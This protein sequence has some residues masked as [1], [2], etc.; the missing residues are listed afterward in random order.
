MTN[1]IP[2]PKIREA[3][4]YL[5]ETAGEHFANESGLRPEFQDERAPRLRRSP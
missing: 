2:T 1:D 5:L 4:Q 3:L